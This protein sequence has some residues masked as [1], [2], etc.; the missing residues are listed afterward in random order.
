MIKKSAEWSGT[1]M[2]TGDVLVPEGVTLTIKPGT[3]VMFVS[4]ES[5]KIEPLYLSMQTELLVRGK[6]LANGTQEDPIIF[7]SA[8]E[9]EDG[10]AIKPKSG[11]WAGLIFDGPG[12][13]SSIVSY[14][15]ISL[16]D[17]AIT[18]INSSPVFNFCEFRDGN[19]GVSCLGDSWPAVCSC[20]ITGN[21][22][23]V[24]SGRGAEMETDQTQVRNN[25]VNFITR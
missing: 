13:S 11:C 12:S 15:Y 21:G 20:K 17:S 9:D 16:A 1:I 5:S 6:L 7:G 22:F 4:S 10:N 18:V 14:A 25:K 23:G 24:L 8:G 2:V 19:Y 3:K